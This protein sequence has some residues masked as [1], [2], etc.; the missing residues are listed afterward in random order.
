[1]AGKARASDTPARPSSGPRKARK[2]CAV[3]KRVR[4]IEGRLRDRLAK[5]FPQVDI[6]D[7]ILDLRPLI[8]EIARD[9]VED[10]DALFRRAQTEPRFRELIARIGEGL[11]R[12][13]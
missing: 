12:R 5:M 9:G 4:R 1:M 2:G 3:D 8:H 7:L 11:A 10:H 13:A 6:R